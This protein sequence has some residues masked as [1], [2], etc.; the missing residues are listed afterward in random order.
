M[1]TLKKKS[2]TN[3]LISI[4]GKQKKE[5]KLNPKKIEEGNKNF[6]AETNEK[7]NRKPIDQVKTTKFG[8]LK[9]STKLSNLTQKY[10]KKQKKINELLKSGLK[11]VIYY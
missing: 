8:F 9:R 6:G 4:L 2:Q 5:S 1:P 7:E 3:N 10:Q 11:V